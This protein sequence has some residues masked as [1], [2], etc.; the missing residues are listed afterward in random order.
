MGRFAIWREK[1]VIPFAICRVLAIIRKFPPIRQS[2]LDE[3]TMTREKTP[4]MEKD[5]P[6]ATGEAPS[7]KRQTAHAPERPC[8]VVG[9][10]ASSGGQGALEQLFAAVPADCGLSFV[11]VM[12]IPPDGPSF[13]AEMLGRYT[14]MDVVTAEEGMGLAPNRVHVIPAGR[15]LAVSGGRL[16]LEE[17]GKGSRA[18]HPVDRLFRSLAAELKEHA[19]AVLLSG[20]GTDGAEGMMAVR[21]AGGTSIV[22]EPRLAIN[23]SMPRSAIATGA[24]DF[25]L[26]AEAIP[27]KI[28][29]IA[30]GT[31]SLI[32]SACRVATL[33]EELGTLFSIVKVQTGHD[34]SSYKSNTVMRRIERRMTVNETG[35][36]R[37]YI[38]LLESN[39]Q[40]AHAL[41]QDILIGVT[42]FF[43]DPEA[44]ATIRQTVL[45]QLF[46]GRDPDDPVR[47]WH[48]CCATGEEVYSMA[49]LIREYL[50][51]HR[52]DVKVQLFATDIDEAAIAQA[53]AGLYGDEIEENVGEERLKTFFTRTDNRWQVVKPVREMIIFAHHS[54]IK[55]PPFSRLDLLVCR[56]FLI[57][58]NPDMQKRL[59]TLFHQVLK[60]GGFLFLG[61]SETVGRHSDL[62]TFVDKKWKIF[63]RR[64]GGRRP[65]TLFPFTTPVRIAPGRTPF[66][67]SA[68][69]LEPSPG[70][71]AEKLLL[72]RYSPPCVVVNEKYEVVHVSTRMGRYLEVPVGEPTRDLLRMSREELRPALRAAIYKCFTEEKEVVFRGVKVGAGGDETAVNVLVEPLK[73]HTSAERLAMVLFEPVPPAPS[74]VPVSPEEAPIGDETSRDMLVRQ[75]EEQLRITHEQLQATTEQL[76]SSNAGFLSANEELISMN[77]EFQSAN[78]ELQSTNEELET[79]K[80]EL[81]ALNEELI[82]VNAELHGKVEELNEATSDMENLLTSS[83]IATIFL[84]RQLTIKRFSPA[85]AAIFNLIPADIGRPF[86]HL[87]GTIDWSGLPRDAETVLGKLVPVER[88]VLAVENGRCCLMRVLPY[89]TTD[90]KVDGI[91]VTLIDITERK[92]MEDALLRAKKEWERTFDSVPDLI[93]IMDDRHRIVRANRA[94]AERLGVTPEA[95][96]GRLCYNSVHGADEPP[97]SCPHIMTLADGREHKVEVH[98]ERLGGDF[99]ITTTPLL[100]EGGQMIGTVHVARDITERKR[101]EEMHARLAAIVES[102]DDAIIAKDLSGVIFS[103]NVGAERLFGYRPDEAVGQPVA[104]LIP[105]ELQMEE[106]HILRRLA[107][108]ERI[109]H[110]ET[111]RLSRDGRRIDVSVTFSPIKHEGRIMGV[112]KIVRDIT[113][114]KRA[115][116]ALRESEERVRRKLDSI[117]SPEG[118]FGN[119]GLADII[120]TRSLQSL[121]DNFYALTRMPMGLIDLKGKVFV[122]VGWQDIC[123]KFHRVN[124]ETCVNCVESDV[125]LSAGVPSGECKIYKCKNNMWDV[126]TPI[127]VGDRHFGNLFMGQFFF[128]DEPIDYE[129]FRSQAR[130]FGFDEN[131]YV[132]A[133]EAVPRLSRETLDTSM[134]FFMKLADILSKLG[135]SNL[136]LAR[137]LSERDTLMESLR[138]SSVRL[139]LLAET[140][141]LLLMSD[142]PQQIVEELCRKVMEFL[143]CHAFFNFLVDEEAGRLRLNA[144]AGIPEEERTKLEWLDYGVAV[145]GC[146]ARDAC[147]IVAEDIPNR[148]DPRTE[149]VKSYGIQAYACHPLMAQGRVLGTLSFGTRT[150]TSFTDD[151]L[152]LMKAVTDQV[153]IAMERMLASQTLKRAHDELEHR[154]EER[155]EELASAVN[156]LQ[157][158]I[159]ERERAEEALRAS[160]KKFR[161]LFEESKD[162]I[163]IMDTDGRLVDVNPAGTE[164]FGYTKDEL[165]ALDPAWELYC[166]P[167]ERELFFQALV[168]DGFVRD[169]DIRMWKKGGG[170]LHLI[171]TA[172][173]VRNEQGAVIGYRGI[174]HDITERK[175]LEE[176]LLQ[177]RKME[178]VGLLAGGVAHDF[179]NMLTAISGYGQIIQEQYAASDEMLGTCIEQLM[180]ATN[181]AVELTRNLL[182]F[183]RKQIITPR[184]LNLSDL[185]ANLIKLLTP[186]IGE[187]IELVTELAERSL[188][189]L[190]DSGQIDQVL[191]NLATNA[192]DAMPQ[193]GR[194]TIRTERTE[195]DEKTTQRY[196]LDKKGA[197]ALISVID[198]GLGMDRQTRERIFEPFYTTKET[199]KGTGL[200]LSII[201]G[202]I[203][204][205][206]GTINVTSEKG[207]G[208]T[209]TICLPLVDVEAGEAE[210]QEGLAPARGVETLLLAEDDVM[211]RKYMGKI[212]DMAGYTVI[213]AQNGAE[214]VELFREHREGIALVLCDVVM[215]KKNGRE[216]YDEI[217]AM[218]PETK[219][220]FLSGYNDEIIHTK[221]I[222]HENIELLTKPVSRQS[223]LQKLREMIDT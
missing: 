134:A 171:Q 222:L 60:T 187:D 148:P 155:T 31:C 61:S 59:M 14:T 16:R 220:L 17:P 203:R 1:L 166:D 216:V 77:E 20:A 82:T 130:N 2:K 6:A 149:L 91:V 34:F 48:A 215:P 115:E 180:A 176:Q 173:A 181:R 9:I 25:I 33:D 195:L 210:A 101:A 135:Y 106:D 138:R 114:R 39:P 52:L 62:F 174:A 15:E 152:A 159:L 103:W 81:Q 125:Q 127:I 221:G 150:R 53:R 177:A 92:R 107:A 198:S 128:E 172:S 8:L 80:E 136:K 102:S 26:P 37:R 73:A 164:L 212:L 7:S 112:S 204:Q 219:F 208:T 157:E 24:A 47:I 142:S 118:D 22:Q 131:E 132:A 87:A 124:P 50:D 183:S 75:L 190:A 104:M 211:V 94:M 192:R 95:C 213:T 218:T 144:C 182:A 68:D 58:L 32:P 158:E 139:D 88:E 74:S 96:I 141:S 19:I 202:I 12:H 116:E 109:D 191:I 201:Y 133:L 111:V 49:F 78:E 11:V 85:M 40:E 207:K 162:M 89:R 13:L 196:G 175:S 163:H 99:L 122:G 51:E 35:G 56:N 214:A 161:S 189:V 205:H 178:S 54:L 4:Q 66:P 41:A 154:V 160:E 86:R 117:L 123:T 69:T 65:D 42:C 121:V 126:A 156:V 119:L 90:G 84:D 143:D 97:G 70:G 21:A 63:A 199:G 194:L 64:E 71:A 67:R 105:S 18:H 3:D 100:D 28:A 147:R 165:L 193:G 206:N 57:Y 55:N 98:E 170:V 23:P 153:A 179:N 110:F 38:A 27:E 200:G 93:A 79:S 30:H 186:I 146:A 209:F 197:Y 137:S 188:T 29:E 168:I 169:F 113:E 36:I 5:G 108:G 10:G 83:E 151:E 140:S 46:A 185:I 129:F 184:P 167:V 145:C 43:R 44:F 217:R 45:P 72:E 76:E 223:L 120:D